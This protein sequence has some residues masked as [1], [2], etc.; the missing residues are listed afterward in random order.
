M[1]SVFIPLLNEEQLVK[2]LLK[3]LWQVLKKT[4]EEFEIVCVD[5]GGTDYILHKLLRFKEKHNNLRIMSLSRNFRLQAASAARDLVVY[6]K[7]KPVIPAKN[8][9]IAYFQSKYRCHH[10]STSNHL[11]INKGK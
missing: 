3:E 7:K 1:I 10:L 9:V 4:G 5:D 8:V 2:R 11:K 6:P